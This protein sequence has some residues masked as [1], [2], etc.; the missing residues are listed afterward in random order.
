[1]SHR[2]DEQSFS[3]ILPTSVI[4]WIDRLIQGRTVFDRTGRKLP[5]SRGRYIRELIEKELF[6]ERDLTK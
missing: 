1:M 4:V 3:L 5:L 6:K 2:N